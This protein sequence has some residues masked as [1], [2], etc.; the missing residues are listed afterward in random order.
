MC[1]RDRFKNLLKTTVRYIRK[2]VGYSLLNVLGLTLG[3]TSALF[4]IIYVS[5]ELSYDRYHEKA[6][7]IYRV[8]SKITETDDQFT[9]IVAQIPFGPQ[10]AQ[11]YPEIESF[12]RFI[13]MP[14]ALYKYEDKE[15]NEENFY[16]ADSTVF[17]IFT[18]KLLSGEVKSAVKDPK[19]IVL[20]KTAAARYFGK[21]DPIGKT[22]TEGANT[23]EVT[24]VIE[25]VPSNSHFR[26]DAIT[27]RN[28]L[29]KQ[30]GSWGN[31]G[32][33]TY[34][35]LPQNLDVKAFETKIQGMYDAYMKQIFGPINI[36]IEYILEPIK[37]IHLYSTNANEPEPTGS[38]TYVYIFGIV[39]IFLILI[40]AMN[41]MNLATARST[42]RARELGLRKVVGS[43]RSALVMQFLGE[44]VALTLISLIISIILMIVLL[45][46]FNLLAGKSFSPEILYSPVVLISLLGIV[47]ITGIFGG[48]YPALF[49]SRFSPVTV[50]KGEITQGSAGSLFRKILVVI[51]FS[52][53]V[54]MIV[55]TLV[56]FR[57]LNYLKNK[58]QGFDQKNV[59]SL[60]LNNREMIRKYPLLKQ[61][62]LGNE[63]IKYVTSTN[64]PMGE[65]SG[66]LVFNV[67]TDQGM[68]QRGIN[69]TVVDHDFVETLGIKIVQGRDFQKDMP[70]DTLNGVLVNETF[71]KRMGWSDPIGKK[72]E[73]GDENTLRA[74]VV[75]VIADY[76]Q[77][78]MYN[79]I[80]SLLLAYREFNNILYIKLSGNNT[81]QTL[82][83]IE[84]KWKEVFPDQ[85]F[86]YT[87]L[88][89]R[90]N[91]QFEADEKRGL[92]FTMFT[93]LAILIACLGLFGLASYMVEQR[94]REVGIRKVFGASEG[95]VIRL[96]SREF[97]ILVT[98][99]IIIAVPAAYLIMSNWLENYIYRT[100]V[101]VPL[102]LLAAGLTLVI[103][104]ITVGYK[105]YQA[106]VMNP[107]N[108]I[109]TE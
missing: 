25:D 56:V 83:F 46:K 47:L 50:L 67:E 90:F 28:N 10:A 52:I 60:Q 109:R 38:I 102:L 95:V 99:S 40:A 105:A 16:Y 8:S 2:H 14:R 11:D 94:T 58:D 86:A 54:A 29:P 84:S 35:L 23:Y 64:T 5:D 93:I 101:G 33:F 45:P 97:L 34:L 89:E 82:S 63:D 41:Y 66:K 27:A 71:V 42:R 103:T 22:L 108:A 81:E 107:A 62:M 104:F 75:G 48:S 91:R 1:I 76:H 21:S 85:P 100:S 49:L 37:R 30:I 9:W 17:D 98:I 53:S 15:Y 74:R 6:D 7:R 24:G 72:I 69:F 57:Q 73:A 43:R 39:A 61:L 80:E 59:V 51:Q 106:S 92:I 36:K 55:C 70:S 68:S 18:F 78:G 4:L 87:Y 88:S 3:I 65:G 31:F 77:T 20:T 13:N 96:I 44:S 12:T 32:V 79:E 26:F 19:K